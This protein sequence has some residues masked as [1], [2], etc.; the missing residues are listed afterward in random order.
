MKK[1][2]FTLTEIIITMGIVGVI[3]MLTI[4]SV[5]KDYKL[6]VYSSLLKKTYSEIQ[7]AVKSAMADEHAESFFVTRSGLAN[8]GT[9]DQGVQYFFRH[10]FKYNSI[11]G[12]LGADSYKTKDGI[13]AKK[14]FGSCIALKSGAVV[15]MS[16]AASTDESDGSSFA[17]DINGKEPPNII[18][19]DAYVLSLTENG[20]LK[21]WNENSSKCQQKSRCT[22]CADGENF[23]H[24]ADYAQGCFQKVVENDWKITED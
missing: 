18:G 15:C 4:P 23:N 21:D 9:N 3:A 10:Y 16:N 17:I 22:G 11:G 19:V 14:L 20:T 8:N 13:N 12:N 2:A 1:L 5:I 7:D 6:R 24:V